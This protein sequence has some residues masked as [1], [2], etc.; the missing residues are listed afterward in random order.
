MRRL[1]LKFLVKPLPLIVSAL[2][3]ASAAQAQDIEPRAFSNA[4]V[5]VNFL[6]AGYAFT[7]GGLSFDP[8]VPVT[9]PK[10]DTSSAVLAYARVF[11]LAGMSAKFDVIAPYTWLSGTAD[12]AGRPVEL[13]G[14]EQIATRGRLNSP[15]EAGSNRHLRPVE[16][17]TPER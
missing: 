8:A 7:R 16:I 1:S 10:L 9:N 2:A 4:P 15:P 17:A 14:P 11:D 12:L 5:G 13:H 3:A 6:I